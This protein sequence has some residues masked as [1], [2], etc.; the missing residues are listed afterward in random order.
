M[1]DRQLETAIIDNKPTAIVALNEN[2]QRGDKIYCTIL[3]RF[4][5]IN[6][7]AVSLTSHE[8]TS[9]NQAA[10]LLFAKYVSDTL[11]RQAI[12]GKCFAQA[13]VTTVHFSS[14]HSNILSKLE[15]LVNT[16]F[17][18]AICEEEFE[19]FRKRA[20]GSLSKDYADTKYRAYLKSLEIC[21]YEAQFRIEE[22]VASLQDITLEE[23]NFYLK[24]MLHLGNLVVLLD[25]KVEEISQDFI[26]QVVPA[27]LFDESTEDLSVVAIP[28]AATILEGDYSSEF[29]GDKELY[30]L[31]LRFYFD[32]DVSPSDMYVFLLFVSA[33]LDVP[34]TIVFNGRMPSII[35]FIEEEC[36]IDASLLQG[37]D[38]ERFNSLKPI[39]EASLNDTVSDPQQFGEVVTWALSQGIPIFDVFAGF[40]NV[41]FEDVSGFIE[42]SYPHVRT[43][44]VHMRISGV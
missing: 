12:G 3:L 41:G 37:L 22:L 26:T 16:L 29:I 5:F 11:M 42:N 35:C 17:S 15:N 23:Y 2:E 44:L 32:E 36:E 28:S 27:S 24:R 13:H 8:E 6:G 7:N 10:P 9:I 34:T 4:G 33:A 25:G 43:G 14:L 1:K 31:T 21:G 39:C 20:Y 38:E 18:K 19:T 30:V 40:T